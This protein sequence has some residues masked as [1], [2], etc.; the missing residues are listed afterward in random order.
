MKMFKLTF[1]FILFNAVLTVA[2]QTQLTAGRFE[3]S[4]R[5]LDPP[6]QNIIDWTIGDGNF[7]SS[8]DQHY[9][10]RKDISF[11]SNQQVT[12]YTYVIEPSPE[13]RGVVAIHTAACKGAPLAHPNQPL[14]T[15]LE[16]SL[17]TFRAPKFPKISSQTN[18]VEII[19][20]FTLA[21][22]V[23]CLS[24]SEGQL[25]FTVP[26]TAAGNARLRFIRNINGWRRV[27]LT[28]AYFGIGTSS[29]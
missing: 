8:L 27:T 22:R 11:F 1:L 2:A 17:G 26:V 12:G 14:S 15:R 21:G 6:P 7:F 23:S 24:G 3:V 18:F 28:S 4:R 16:M 25:G 10:S 13:A 29:P 19:V 5:L 20:P 9:Q